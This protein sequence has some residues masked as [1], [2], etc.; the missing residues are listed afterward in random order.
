[1]RKNIIIILIIIALIA[2]L[3]AFET[4]RPRP[5]DWSFDFRSTSK[6]PYGC[7]VYADMI[8]HKFPDK[9]FRLI[10]NNLYDS[11]QV[12]MTE[13]SVMY[14]HITDHFDIDSLIA[15][16]IINHVGKGNAVFISAQSFSPHFLKITGVKFKPLLPY[17]EKT[18][19]VF[20]LTNPV[21]ARKPYNY[22][23]L[24][25][26]I[27]S[28]FDSSRTTI[29]GRLKNG[30]V[31]FIR[32]KLGKGILFLHTAPEVFTNYN[33]LNEN[34][35]Y[36]MDIMAYFR[37]Y[38]FVWDDYLKPGNIFKHGAP[39]PLR[40]ILS[41]PALKMAYYILI[42]GLLIFIIFNAKRK[43][44]IIPVIQPPVNN[45]LEFVSTIS[46][47]Y[48]STDDHKYMA[49]LKFK[50]FCEYIFFHFHINLTSDDEREIALLAEKTGTN[51]NLL[52]EIIT[53]IKIIN[54]KRKISSKELI[55]YAQQIDKMYSLI[56]R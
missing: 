1:M 36:P 6:K 19:M 20:E 45:T 52:A 26:G 37:G 53:G 16:R 35:D 40:Y 8:K 27:F 49:Q 14:F 48:Q 54:N 34:K 5:V 41:N 21:F 25:L 22:K 39:S 42:S 15:M 24:F 31:N 11:Y 17:A 30:Q 7:Y 29:L 43:Q 23:K 44:R 33:I 2:L 13:K 32:I 55:R 9:Q 51:I 46:A 38:D 56:N 12:E 3:I 10:N 18:Q 50:H 28:S 4:L 47:L